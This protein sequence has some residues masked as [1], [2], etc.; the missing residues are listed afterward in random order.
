MKRLQTPIPN[1]PRHNM[2]NSQSEKSRTWEIVNC[3]YYPVVARIIDYLHSVR[4]YRKIF[5][6]GPYIDIFS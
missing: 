2:I 3:I 1:F 6:H 5:F 4:L